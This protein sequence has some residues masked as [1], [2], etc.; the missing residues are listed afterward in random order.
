MTTAIRS[1]VPASHARQ[2]LEPGPV[3]MLTTHAGG[4][5]NVMTMGWHQVLEF[6]PRWSAASLPRA[7]RATRCCAPAANA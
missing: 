7:T 1:A 6:T 2:F 4:A 3:V 5:D